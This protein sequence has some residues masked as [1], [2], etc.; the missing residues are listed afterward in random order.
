MK[1]LCNPK[2]G[3]LQKETKKPVFAPDEKIKMNMKYTNKK[4]R[5]DVQPARER[6]APALVIDEKM[7]QVL[8]A[9]KQILAAAM[10]KQ[11]KAHGREAAG[12]EYKDL[13]KYITDMQF[14]FVPQALMINQARDYLLDEKY[15]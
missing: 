8:N 15:I 10:V 12:V 13:L 7:K 14:K 2:I 6:A 3:V 11:M 9:R 4:I 5:L 1:Q